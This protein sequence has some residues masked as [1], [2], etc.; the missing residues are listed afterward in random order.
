MRAVVDPHAAIKDVAAACI[1]DFQVAAFAHLD[2]TSRARAE[3]PLLC[4]REHP[5]RVEAEGGMSDINICLM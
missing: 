2:A 5:L 3:L 4:C 1:V